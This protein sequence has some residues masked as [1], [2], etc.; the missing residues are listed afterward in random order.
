M[1]AKKVLVVVG[2][3]PEAI[4]LAPL[5][6]ALKQCDWARCEVVLTGQHKDMVIPLLADFAIEAD[7]DLGPMRPNQTLSEVTAHILQKIDA[8][9]IDKRPD[10]VIGQGDTASVLA[11]SMACFFQQI[12][13]AHVEAG[14][15]TGNPK[16]PFPEEMNRVLTG[17]L[18]TWHFA[19]T[20][21]AQAHLLAE[22]VPAQSIW[23][24]GNTVIDALKFMVAKPSP[25]LPVR[26]GRNFI[27]ITAHRRESLGEA[28]DRVCQAIAQLARAHPEL[29]F[30]FPVHPN[31]VVR[32]STHR[33]LVN[34]P[35]VML[36]EPCSYPVFCWLMYR[37]LFILSDSGGVQEEA[38]A[39][40]KPVLVLR[41]ETERPEALAIGAT[42]LVGTKVQT[43]VE[44]AELLLADPLAYE[45]MSTAGSP[46]G[47]GQAANL[48]VQA[49][50]HALPQCD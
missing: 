50:A 36:I 17:R 6:L 46:Y 43:I 48:I 29:D 30:V 12:P 49:L 13:F 9:L 2:T 15:R 4:K 18:A 5:I 28:L 27:L 44:T 47:D 37:S 7:H 23:L 42:K 41:D 19:P 32:Q 40:G 8:L 10:V 1:M 16:L 11:T 24:T 22:N 39:L 38:P 34:M 33:H 26:E 21:V 20:D 31:P 14:L 3:R 45:Q 25:A 35:N